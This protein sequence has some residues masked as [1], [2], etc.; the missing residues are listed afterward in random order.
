LLEE[1]A[2]D[3][4]DAQQQRA[5]EEQL[6]QPHPMLARACTSLLRATRAKG[7]LSVKLALY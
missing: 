5:A 6:V 2:R 1:H 7:G 3:E 4:D